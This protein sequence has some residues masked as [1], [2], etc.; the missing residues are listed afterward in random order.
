MLQSINNLIYVQSRF[1]MVSPLADN[2]K[3]YDIIKLIFAD[4]FYKLLQIK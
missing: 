2:T 1:I 3:N 4:I